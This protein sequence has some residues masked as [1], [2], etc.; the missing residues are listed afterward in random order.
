MHWAVPADPRV[1]WDRAARLPLTPSAD[2]RKAAAVACY[3]SQLSP[4]SDAPADAAVVPPDVLAHFT[5]T[6]EVFFR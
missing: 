4:L 1:P 2:V 6:S 5:R 3:V